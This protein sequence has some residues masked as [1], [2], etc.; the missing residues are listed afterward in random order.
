MPPVGLCSRYH[1]LKDPL[2]FQLTWLLLEFQRLF[3]LLLVNFASAERVRGDGDRLTKSHG[4][5]TRTRDSSGA[6][7]AWSST[8][9]RDSRGITE[10]EVILQELKELILEEDVGEVRRHKS[11]R[12]R[13]NRGDGQRE[14]GGRQLGE[15]VIQFGEGTGVKFERQVKTSKK[16]L[17][18]IL[19]SER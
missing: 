19:P 10:E 1:L 18:F 8:R 11:R 7:G 4:T 13:G 12:L 9:K 17:S 3:C 5:R 14:R 2:C 15:E 16:W 6:W